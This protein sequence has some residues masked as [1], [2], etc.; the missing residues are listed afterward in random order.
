MAMMMMMALTLDEAGV[1]G[2]MYWRLEA[3][4]DGLS[5]ARPGLASKTTGSFQVEMLGP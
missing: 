2:N 3:Y 5:N 4:E 1:T